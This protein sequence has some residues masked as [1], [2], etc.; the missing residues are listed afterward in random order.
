MANLEFITKKIREMVDNSR[1]SKKEYKEEVEEILVEMGTTKEELKNNCTRQLVI[2]RLAET[3]S[4]EEVRD[5]LTFYTK[6]TQE[7][8]KITTLKTILSLLT[9]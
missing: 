7:R 4:E 9:D 3:N 8:R 1:G 2:K 6:M 5:L